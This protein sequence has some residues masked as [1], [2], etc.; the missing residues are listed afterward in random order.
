MNT[1]D[2]ILSEIEDSH[3]KKIKK[4]D[5]P[6]IKADKLPIQDER[7]F[8]DKQ[9]DLSLDMPISKVVRYS[10]NDLYLLY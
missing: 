9:N 3:H 2:I 4:Q 7:N 1:E 6:R 5:E 8:E 10:E